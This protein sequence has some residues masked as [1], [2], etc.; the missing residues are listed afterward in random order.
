[1]NC[2]SAVNKTVAINDYIVSNDIDFLVLTETWFGKE[3][4]N[5][6]LSELTPGIT[7]GGGLAVIHKKNNMQYQT[8]FYRRSFHLF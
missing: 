6:I 2:R 3:T 4:D 5:V 1:M 8:N 7:G